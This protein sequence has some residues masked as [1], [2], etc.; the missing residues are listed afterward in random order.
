M[1]PLTIENRLFYRSADTVIEDYPRLAPMRNATSGSVALIATRPKQVY[2]GEGELVLERRMMRPAK[3]SF[4]TEEAFERSNWEPVNTTTF[5]ALWDAEVAELPDTETRQLHLLTGLILPIWTEIP[6]DNTRI[7]RVQ[8]EEGPALLGRALDETQASV[9]RGKF[10]DLD[11]AT[12][13]DM[14]RIVLDTDRAVE[15]GNGFSLKRRRVAGHQR[16]ELTGVS[17]DSLP[18]LKSLGCFTEIHQYQLRVFVP[19]EPEDQALRVL[20]AIQSGHTVD[21]PG[22]IAAE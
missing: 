14:L 4:L 5:R 8:P 15:L 11:A 17:K 3:K 1:V 7:Y 2:G 22:V 12:P 6:G 20:T 16:L 13:T 9:L 10:M 19:A 21:E 18:W